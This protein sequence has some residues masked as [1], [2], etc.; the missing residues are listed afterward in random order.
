LET[1]SE[2]SGKKH[3]G[4]I[5]EDAVGKQIMEISMVT[6]CQLTV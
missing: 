4:N 5:W 3:A 6:H 1:V 2:E